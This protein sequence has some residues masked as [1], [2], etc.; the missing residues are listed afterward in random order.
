MKNLNTYEEFLNESNN[1]DITKLS[2]GMLKEIR[3][4]FNEVKHG[5]SNTDL[6]LLAKITMEIKKRGIKE[7][8][9]ESIVNEGVASLDSYYK[10]S[11][12]SVRESAKKIDA[13]L[14]KEIK[15]DATKKE[16]LD[17]ITDMVEEYAFEFADNRDQ[18]RY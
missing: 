1:M 2:D 3:K 11:E 14:N 18:E 12:K 5:L 7:S 15:S 9:K 16:L 8:V 6:A 4:V 10:N 17:L 13:I